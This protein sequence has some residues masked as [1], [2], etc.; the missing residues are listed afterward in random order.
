MVRAPEAPPYARAG[1][2]LSAAQE[3]IWDSV[4]AR[5]WAFIREVR[6]IDGGTKLTKAELD[7]A[8]LEKLIIA[9]MRQRDFYCDGDGISGAFLANETDRI[10]PLVAEHVALPPRGGFFDPVDY[11]IDTMVRDSYED[12]DI[13]LVGGD[14]SGEP[15]SQVVPRGSGLSTSELLKLCNF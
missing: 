15:A 3:S 9:E 7:F 10:A 1:V 13:L 11:L 12:P 4:Y 14:A 6:N 8:E 5:V 2:P